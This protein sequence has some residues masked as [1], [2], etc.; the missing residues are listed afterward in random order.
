[1]RTRAKF[2]V[3]AVV[4]L[5]VA[6]LVGGAVDDAS[7]P[8]SLVH[9]ERT[10]STAVALPGSTFRVVVQIR[11]HEDLIGVGLREV[12][13]LG[14][15]IHPIENE[16]AAFK[17]TENEWVFPSGLEANSTTWVVYELTVPS[18]DRLF[19]GSLPTCFDLSGMFQATLNGIEIPVEGDATV[20]IASALPIPTAVAH[21][22]PGA[23][24]GEDRVDLRLDQTITEEQLDRALQLWA[25]DTAIPWTGGETIDLAMAEKLVALHL[26]CTDS[27]RALPVSVDPELVAVRAIDTSLPCDSVLLPEDCLNPGLA[28][29]RFEVTVRITGTHNA[30]GI[31]L[32]EWFPETWRVTPRDRAGIL[33]RPSQNEWLYPGRLKA[34]ETLEIDYE[35]EVIAST[36]DRLLDDPGCCGAESPFV[37]RASSGLECSESLVAGET[38][39][40]VWNCLPVLLA[41][42]RWD[43]EEDRLDAS[44]SDAITFP[45]VQR[46][47]EFWLSGTPVP[48]T[49]GYTVGYHML[50]TIVGHWLSGT[51]ITQPLPDSTSDVCGDATQDCPQPICPQDGLCRL[52]DLQ[53]PE[54]YV[55]IPQLPS[56]SLEIDGVQELTCADSSTTLR[57]VVQGGFPPYRIEWHAVDGSLLGTAEELHVVSP[58]TYSATIRSAGGC[59]VGRQVT[60]T[61]DYESPTVLIESQGA[62]GCQITEV[63]LSAT[64][65]GG[66]GPFV[67][68]WFDATGTLIGEDS[69]V[70]V[71]EPGAFHVVV[72][73]ANGCVGTADAVVVEERET[74]NVSAGPDRLLTC[75]VPEVLLEGSASGGV[76][77][78]VYEWT[79]E[80][81]VGISD[82]ATARVAEPGVYRLTV[83]GANGCSSSDSVQVEQ[84]L[85]PPALTLAVSGAI[86]CAHPN[87]LLSVTIEGGRSPFTIEWRDSGGAVIGSSE[88][89]AVDLSGTYRVTVTGANGCSATESMD[90]FE[91]L[92][93]PTLAV[94]TDGILSCARTEVL[95]RVETSGGRAPLAVEWRDPSGVEVGQTDEIHAGQPGAYTVTVTGANGCATTETVTV[96]QDIAAPSVEATV[97]GVL[98]CANPV[99]QLYAAIEGGRAPYTVSWTDGGGNLVGDSPELAI[100]Q[101]DTYTVR[102]TGGN[103]CLSMDTVVVSQDVTAPSVEVSASG[104]LNCVVGQ[105]ELL[106]TIS[107]GRA[108]HTIA[109]SDPSGTPIG[110]RTD[111]ITVKEPGTYS[112][113]VVGGNGCVSTA[114]IDVVEDIAVPVIQPSVAGPLTCDVTRVELAVQIEGGRAPFSTAWTDPSGVAISYAER[115]EVEE[116]GSYTVTVTGANGC[117]ASQVVTVE[118]DT[119]APQVEAW[120]SGDLSCAAPSVTLQVLIEGGREPFAVLWKDETGTAIGSSESIM[121]SE[122]GTYI[123]TVTGANGCIGSDRVAVGEDLVA[124]KLT[125]TVGGVLTCDTRS[126]LLQVETLAG[127]AP[128]AF[129]WTDPSGR[130]IANTDAVD[131]SAPGTYSVA[132]TGANGCTTS[133]SVTVVEDTAVPVIAASVSGDLTCS[134]ETVA[135]HAEIHGGREPYATAWRNPSG[136]A[137]STS[138]TVSVDAPGVYTVSVTGANGCTAVAE[139]VVS[140]D[141]AVPELEA[142]VDGSLSCQTPSA[143][144][145]VVVH[146]GRAPF[147]CVWSDCCG[148]QIGIGRTIEVFTPG[149]YVV[150][151]TGANGCSASTAVE[152]FEDFEVPEVGLHVDGV[153]TCAVST[154]TLTATVVGGRPPYELTWTDASGQILGW[155]LALAVSEAGSYTATAIGANGC[156]G[157]ASATVVEDTLPPAFD[158]GEDRALTCEEPEILLSA[159]PTQGMAPFEYLWFDDC[160]NVLGSS[161]TLSVSLPG[162]YRATVTGANGCTFS[163]AVTLVDGVN[164][165]MVDLGPDRDMVCCGDAMVLQ[166]TVTGGLQPYTYEWR[167]DCDHVIGTDASVTIVQPGSYLLIV[168]TADGCMGSDTIVIR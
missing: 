165:P 143:T 6:S 97:S 38:S 137:I 139:L 106:A 138:E 70:V 160:D 74:P 93:A 15:T 36:T 61:A 59:Q 86:D 94:S 167:D 33:Y 35:V 131:V 81:G 24:L 85:A 10:L 55:G 87:A 92:A 115:V 91:D 135:L 16:G 146:G 27:D 67:I 69:D 109:W 110:D 130:V 102:V 13:P 164:P 47:V 57:A 77:P 156:S 56:L 161:P 150:T 118:Q 5:C 84:D 103:G 65:L 26:T 1:M 124:P 68:E 112:V 50:K 54:D 122:P 82:E 99:V 100:S 151:V 73:G 63:T 133:S 49:C 31:G 134:V 41:I 66:R 157:L 96:S 128:Y 142:F 23:G 149:T 140:Q 60:V 51:A 126:V 152:V 104:E 105:V 78:F 18:A 88:T 29:R 19:A 120:S 129:V 163:D 107:D 14:W 154:V 71:D 83:I 155:G 127:R 89:V 32:A 7:E 43:V 76:P 98:T 168:R 166:C 28:A 159:V 72:V 147:D 9:V 53:S 117:T 116:P 141:V 34:G 132:V 40:Y 44:L 8:E 79:N 95:L 64:I 101:P 121:V 62:L 37:G 20:E 3:L 144:L 158:L 30:Y 75:A 25:M 125:M 21:L 52:T 80:K 119:V 148:T 123:A 12:V 90:V 108:P 111:R 136:E 145:N 58:G 11:A 39:V 46:A 17:R 22:V 162:T 45:Q 2:V 114:E 42:S 4:L 153:L 48:H 113:T